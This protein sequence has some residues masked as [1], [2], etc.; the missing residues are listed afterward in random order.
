MDKIKR[1]GVIV[2]LF[3][4]Y[5][6]FAQSCLFTEDK[7]LIDACVWTLYKWTKSNDTTQNTFSLRNAFLGF[8]RNI[9][10]YLTA[11]L[12]LNVG[13]T[14]GKPAYDLY[15]SLKLKNWEMR[16]GQF[17]QFLGQE[18]L[19]PPPK[20]NFIEYS[21]IGKE[22]APK[23]P[24]DV[25]IMIIGRDKQGEIALACVNGTGKNCLSDDNKWKDLSGRLALQPK[26]FILGGNFYY[27]KLGKDESLKTYQ[28]WGLELGI[29][30]PLEL[31]S[32]FLFL[33]D[34]LKGKGFYCALVYHQKKYQPLFR[35]DWLEYN[36]QRTVSYTLGINL[37]FL[38]GNFTQSETEVLKLGLNWTWNDKRHWRVL[39][40]LQIAY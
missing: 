13:D 40:Q 2:Y 25:G 28:R 24:R 23:N 21:L 19:L 39:S 4:F 20:L 27:G 38:K 34:T 11:R 33:K 5:L 16:V 9:N 14:T 32:E 37:L 31:S 8:T 22:R 17:K 29:K 36:A 10:K 30:A 35:Y 7:L 18:C 26:D 6:G 3:T 15:A 12:Y 1:L